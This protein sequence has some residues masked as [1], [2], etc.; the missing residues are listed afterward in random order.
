MEKKLL[1]IMNPYS[2]QK[3]G[4]RYLAEILEMFCQEGYAP[5]TFMTTGPGHATEIARQYAA[6]MD[7][8]VCMGGDGTFNEVVSGMLAA[9]AHTPI[10]YIPCGSTNDFA[11]SLKLKKNL[12]KAAEDILCGTPQT[13]D[14]GDFNGRYFS[15]IAS[16]GAF[17]RA[18]YATPQAVKNT[19]GHLAYILEG[20]KD[21]TN[22]RPHHLV[23]ET[24]AGHFED[25]YLFGAVSNATSV[26][27]V[28]NLDPA[29]IDMNDGL[30]ELLLIKKPKNALELN[31]CIWKLQA[32]NYDSPMLTF[33]SASRLTVTAPAAMDWTLDGEHQAGAERIEIRNRR[34]AI[35]L[36]IPSREDK[37]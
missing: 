32:Q 16:F 6:A 25:D 12:R 7:L 9:E 1:L 26:G 8:V 18:S 10:G 19:L 29:K 23:I 11:N 27:G 22:I 37:K 34:D 33:H 13:L 5:L 15:Y 20:L 31:D 24:D 3:I 14:V 28:L 2:G 17:T 30:L 36:V 21:I 4:R 35:R